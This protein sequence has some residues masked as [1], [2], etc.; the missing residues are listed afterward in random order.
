MASA[1]ATFD[2]HIARWHLIPDGAP[3]FTRSS[4]LLPVRFDGAAA[5]LKIA[6]VEEE[7]RG[8][9]LIAWWDG[10]GAALVL[11]QADDAVLLERLDDDHALGNMARSGADDAASRIICD[12][13]ARL[14]TARAKPEP[15]L[16][17]LSVWFEDLQGAADRHGGILATAHATARA[18]LESQSDVVVLHGDIHHGNI[19]K[20]P[21]RG[22]VAIDPKGLLGERGF[23][24]ANIFCNPDDATATAPGRL[25][26]QVAIVAAAARLDR[27][28]LMQWIL[29]YAGLSAAWLMQDGAAPDARLAVAE[30]AAAELAALGLAPPLR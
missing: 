9:D 17:P 14:H 13:A 18:L 28:R 12:V 5:M 21:T 1:S 6:N 25:S 7:R 15:E 19:L 2:T 27:V 4:S 8:N 20:S 29:A 16:V 23:D 26:R 30:I 24:F 11:A 22:W 3:L 10:D